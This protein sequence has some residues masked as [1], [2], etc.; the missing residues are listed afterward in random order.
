MSEPRDTGREAYEAPALTTVGTVASLTQSHQGWC[1]PV[2]EKT[3]GP[4]DYFVWIPITT[5]S[6]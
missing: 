2:V 4:P 1:V 5:C 6:T 3:I